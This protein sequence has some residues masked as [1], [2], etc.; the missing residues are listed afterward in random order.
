[1]AKVEARQ[2]DAQDQVRRLGEAR[3]RVDE[4]TKERSRIAGELGAVQKRLEELEKKCQAEFECKVDELPALVA[5]MEDE[6][7]KA[8]SQAEQILGLVEQEA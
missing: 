3:A 7:E 2:A 8:L 6:A 4:L 1:V 5:Q